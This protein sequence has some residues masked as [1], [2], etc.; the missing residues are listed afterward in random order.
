MLCFVWKR[1]CTIA[2]A[3]QVN[4]RLG[5]LVAFGIPRRVREIFAATMLA[6]LQALQAENGTL[7]TQHKSTCLW[8]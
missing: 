3:D 1:T 8:K 5:G 2:A 6:S 7:V 4:E